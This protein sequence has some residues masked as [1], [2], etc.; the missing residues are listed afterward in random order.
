MDDN[1]LT[2]VQIVRIPDDGVERFQ[3]YESIV[4]PI[5]P[6]YGGRL[7]GRYRDDA[8]TVEIHVVSFPS[9]EAIDGYRKDERRQAV[10]HLLAE[11]GATPELHQVSRVD[12]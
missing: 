8:G 10:Q 9:L 12:S 1:R 3:E 4:L 5:L 2:W 7:E 6:E 11:S